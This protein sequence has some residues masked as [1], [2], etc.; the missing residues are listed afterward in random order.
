MAGSW[1]RSWGVLIAPGGGLD[2]RS[3]MSRTACHWRRSKDTA[4]QLDTCSP[5]FLIQE[6]NLGP[7]HQ[8]IFKEPSV[9][10]NGYVIPPTGPGSGVELDGEVL[11]HHPVGQTSQCVKQCPTRVG[12]TAHPFPERRPP[13]SGWAR[14]TGETEHGR[15][16]RSAGPVIGPARCFDGAERHD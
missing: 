12:D 14:G 6:A 1:C 16:G 13:L 5:N 9:F 4:I 8:K 3:R 7:L 2:S 15:C 10:E 11:R